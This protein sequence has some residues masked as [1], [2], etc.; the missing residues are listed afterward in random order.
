MKPSNIATAKQI[1]G[2]IQKYILEDLPA[3]P[4]WYNGMW[5]QY[6]TTYWTNFPSSTGTGLQTRRATWNGYLNM[7]GIDA[8]ARSSRSEVSSADRSLARRTRSRRLAPGGAAA[9]GD[10][11]RRSRADRGWRP[12]TRYLARKILLYL[13]DLLR[14]GDDRLG[15]PAVHAGRPDRRP[16]LPD[17]RPTRR[18]AQELARAT[19]RSRSGSTSR[20]GSSTSNFWRGL[21][22][23]D[24]GL[25]I[26]YVGSSVSDL[27][28]ARV[29]YTLALLV[30]AIVLSYIAGN[31]VGA[32]AARRKSL[33][34]TVL[35]LAYVLTATPYMWLALMLAYFFAFQWGIFPISGAYDFSLQPAWTLGVR[36]ELP[37]HWFLPFLSLFLVASAAGRSGCGT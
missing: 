20:S 37:D 19:S 18:P 24:L 25:S 28:W 34:N 11:R 10:H 21:L 1:H 15:H 6:N 9:D 32:L 22:H 14:R 23:G 8:L 2:Q 5:S 36:R 35:P 27:I 31:R 12:V 17:S 33:D 26:A 13:A 29:P 7:T 3:I 16:H 4:L 30:P